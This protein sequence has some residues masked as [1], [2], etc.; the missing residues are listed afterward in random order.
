MRFT[1]AFFGRITTGLVTSYLFEKIAIFD[2]H[3]LHPLIPGCKLHDPDKGSHQAYEE[4]NKTSGVHQDLDAHG[5]SH[6][7][8]SLTCDGNGFVQWL[9]NLDVIMVIAGLGISL[10][11]YVLLR[12]QD[13]IERL[14]AILSITAIVPY[15]L[16]CMFIAEDIGCA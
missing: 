4:W 10:A 2:L 11:I 9:P 6:D 7:G 15:L 1:K 8:I 13:P 14:A 5:S 16:L 3:S 12:R